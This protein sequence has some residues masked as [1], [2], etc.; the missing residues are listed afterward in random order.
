MFGRELKVLAGALIRTLFGLLMW[1]VI[2]RDDMDGVFLA[3]YQDAP[4]DFGTTAFYLA[5]RRQIEDR[6]LHIQSWLLY[7]DLPFSMW[8]S[9]LIFSSVLLFKMFGNNWI[10]FDGFFRSGYGD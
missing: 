9:A 10:A 3:P 7:V 4:L 1:N 5:R 6:L 2:W 8:S